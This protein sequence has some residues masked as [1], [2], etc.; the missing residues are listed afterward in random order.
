MANGGF[1]TSVAGL[2]DVTG[3]GRGDV[4][5]GAPRTSVAAV[6]DPAQCGRAYIISGATGRAHRY[7]RSPGTILN[8]FFGESVSAVPDATGD[9]V[10]DIAVGAPLEHPGASPVGCGR[11]Y[12]FIG[13][14]GS[15]FKKLIPPLQQANGEFGISV[16]GVPDTN[17]DGRGDVI[18]GAWKEAVGAFTQ[19]GRAHLYSGNTAA[20]IAT[21]TSTQPMTDGFFAGMITGLGPATTANGGAV[22]GAAAETSGGLIDA[23]RAYVIRR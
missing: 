6:G 10:N 1:G 18:V 8:G 16:S 20:R 14:S 4:V 12:I 2:A 9:G 23:G 13:Q 3:D 17:G 5:V 7:I 15:L 21:Y 11:A 19:A 22:V